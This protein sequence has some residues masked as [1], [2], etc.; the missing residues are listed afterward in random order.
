MDAGQKVPLKIADFSVD[1]RWIFSCSF[2]N[3]MAR[4]FHHGNQTPK[5]MS[6]FREGVSLTFSRDSREFRDSRELPDC[7]KQKGESN[8]SL[9]IL[10]NLEISE[11]LEIR[12]S[13]EIGCSTPALLDTKISSL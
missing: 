4:K 9:E 13:R 12:G 1:F 2:P 3:K 5:S 8:H 7:G 6:N 10:E 11:I